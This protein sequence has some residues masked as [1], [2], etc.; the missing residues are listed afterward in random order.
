M[1]AHMRHICSHDEAG[2]LELEFAM[3]WFTAPRPDTTLISRMLTARRKAK[4]FPVGTLFAQDD[5]ISICNSILMCNML[6]V[7]GHA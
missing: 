4:A 5:S 3:I 1:P 2:K 6:C 7:A